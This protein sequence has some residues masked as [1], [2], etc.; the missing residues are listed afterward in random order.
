[1]VPVSGVVSFS[2][3]AMADR[4]TYLPLIGLFLMLVW[5]AADL[6]A[7]RRIGA[8][9]LAA[10]TAALLCA[11]GILAGAQVRLW[12]D[13]ATLFSHAL[14]LDPGN[15]V[16]Q[17]VLGIVAGNR[18]DREGAIEHHVAALRINPAYNKAKTNLALALLEARRYEEARSVLEALVQ[19]QPGSDALRYHLGNAYSAL[20]RTG[21]AVRAFEE[22]IR[23]N[24]R[25]AQA[26]NNLGTLYEQQGRLDDALRAYA[27]AAA[28]DPLFK[29]ALYNLGMLN[30]SRGDLEAARRN[31][32]ALAKVDPA[33]AGQ[34]SQFLRHFSR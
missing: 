9:A 26:R 3:Q 10:A 18:G 19:R 25:H 7:A 21:E 1:M 20:G 30:I 23:L 8:P 31:H 13:T 24:P 33:A 17:D 6:A 32:E 11:L 27:A 5:G 34:L 14:E 28:A 4:F 16:A 29:D 2:S 15:Y 22:A 12:R